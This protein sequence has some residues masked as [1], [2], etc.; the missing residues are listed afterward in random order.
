MKTSAII[1]RSINGNPSGLSRYF[2]TTLDN[3]SS[4]N[5]SI[6]SSNSGSTH[7]GGGGKMSTYTSNN[8]SSI[9][10]EYQKE[11]ADI[12]KSFQDR[13]LRRQSIVGIVTSDKCSKSITVQH[14]HM[15]YFPKYN[16]MIPRR[17]KI[18]AHDED[19]LGEIGDVVRIVPCRPMSRKKRHKLMDVLKKAQRLD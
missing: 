17:K 18:M 13:I 5:S 1:R 12:Q 16:K 6:N 19:E 14:T 9:E 3:S 7:G 2:S 10:I 11:I 4:I 15:K 8:Y